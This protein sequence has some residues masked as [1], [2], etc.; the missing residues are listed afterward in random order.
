MSTKKVSAKS[1]SPSRGKK[2]EKVVKIK[3]AMQ[4][5]VTEKAAFMQEKNAYTFNV[6]P[7]ANK[8]E[9]KKSILAIYKVKPTKVNILP[10]PKKRTFYKGKAGVRGGGRKAVVY[11]KKGDKIELA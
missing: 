1:G 11:L 7:G 8:A 5:R 6:A 3:S 9:I 4:A 10:V 2:K